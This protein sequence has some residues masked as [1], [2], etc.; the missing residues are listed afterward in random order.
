M[1]KSFVRKYIKYLKIPQEVQLC[2]LTC[3]QMLSILGRK[4]MGQL[5]PLGQLQLAA[6]YLYFL[7]NTQ[8]LW[9]LLLVPRPH[10]CSV[11]KRQN[12][13]LIQV[14]I[15][16]SQEIS[17]DLFCEKVLAKHTPTD[18]TFGPLLKLKCELHYTVSSLYRL[19]TIPALHYTGSSLYRLFTIPATVMFTFQFLYAG[20]LMHAHSCYTAT[21]LLVY[22]SCRQSDQTVQVH[23]NDFIG[24]QKGSSPIVSHNLSGLKY[25]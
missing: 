22:S 1:P 23:V 11:F 16:P 15:W 5:C 8:R 6:G 20:F 14:A 24:I 25:I 2:L 19:F 7:L 21:V 9:V 4:I 18:Q 10:K 12:R 3:R 13:N 17:R